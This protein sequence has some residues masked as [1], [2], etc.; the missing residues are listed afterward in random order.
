MLTVKEAARLLEIEPM[1]VY[2]WMKLGKLR[3]YKKGGYRRLFK[4]ED[5]DQ[6]LAK[7]SQL[8]LD[9][10][11]RERTAE[12]M[13]FFNKLSANL[14]EKESF[15]FMFSFLS[16]REYHELILTLA[17]K[18]KVLVPNWFIKECRHWGTIE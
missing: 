3:S 12:E 14:T 15:Q 11:T 16:E 6:V 7:K 17:K 8:K 9:H 10:K 2:R 18:Y 4:R 13:K 5:I 1:T